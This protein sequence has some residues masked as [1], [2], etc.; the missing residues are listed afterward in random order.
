[1]P[2][3]NKELGKGGAEMVSIEKPDIQELVR[4]LEK[5]DKISLLLIDSGAKLLVAR[6]NMEK[7]SLQNSE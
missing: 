2:E 7:E 3:T 4:A 6:Q 5:L 1:M